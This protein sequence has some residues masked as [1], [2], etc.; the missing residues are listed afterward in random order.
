MPEP[1]RR[2]QP[3]DVQHDTDPARDGGLARRIP[4]LGHALLFFFLTIACFAFCLVVLALAFHRQMTATAGMQPKLYVAAASQALGYLMALALTFPLFPLLWHDGFLQGISWTWRQARLHWWQLLLVGFALSAGAQLSEHLVKAPK[5]TEIIE[6]F[7]NP[8]SAWL[9]A[10][11]GGVLVPIFEEIAFRGFL[12]PAFAI[13]YDWLSLERTPAARQRWQQTVSLTRGAWVFASLVTSALFVALHGSQ[14][15][16][17]FGALAVLFLPS[18][19][20]CYVRIRF[21]SVAA[22]AL[23]HIAYDSL[24]FFEIFVSTGGFRH[25]EKLAG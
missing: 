25:L 2:D 5:G 6:L 13:A 7:R 23:V 1:V 22:A 17:A 11:F 19:V 21:R 20:F 12:L 3:L 8:I 24:I 16:W 9:T 15:H 18:I 4:H 10:C 14:L